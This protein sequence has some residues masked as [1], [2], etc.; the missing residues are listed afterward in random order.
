M[1]AEKAYFTHS[2]TDSNQQ[3]VQFILHSNPKFQFYLDKLAHPT[4][5]HGAKAAGKTKIYS[6]DH[7]CTEKLAALISS[8][9][10]GLVCI[11]TVY[12]L[13][14]D[15]AP[16]EEIANICNETGSIL[17]ADESHALGMFGPKGSGIVPML[18]LEN[19]VPIRTASLGKA[20]GALGG[21]IAFSPECTYMRE[22]I[23]TYATMSV[24]SQAPQDSRV[25]RFF[26][27]LDIIESE[28]GKLLRKELWEKSAYFRKGC[29]E[30]G[31]DGQSVRGE[32]PII[33]FVIG[34]IAETK[35]IYQKFVANKIYPSA[36]FYPVVPLNKSIIRW[37]LCTTISW[38]E[39]AI[40]LNFLEEKRQ[41]FKPWTWS[42]NM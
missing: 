25:A 35:S 11:D 8:H 5:H 36:G 41:E 42:W 6:F 2:G 12:S 10:P 28:A 40:T 27:T 37:T 7:N 18:G 30:R 1:G 16:I 20:F 15:V 26:G 32:G 4:M 19:V 39:I 33:S 22:L 31:Y 17:L 14:G 34:N 21:I 24:F 9:G 38:E 13:L 3:I 29:I 23:P